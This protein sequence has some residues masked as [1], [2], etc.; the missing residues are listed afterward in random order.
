MTEYLVCIVAE[1]K[2][3]HTG[4]LHGHKVIEA[5]TGNEAVGRDHV[6]RP[7]VVVVFKSRKIISLVIDPYAELLPQEKRS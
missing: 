7:K 5:E 3:I 4:H 1:A 6:R 2:D